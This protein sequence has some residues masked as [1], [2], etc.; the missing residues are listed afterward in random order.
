MGAGSSDKPSVLWK[1]P[2]NLS[3]FPLSSE[4]KARIASSKRLQLTT[5]DQVFSP[6]AGGRKV[7]RFKD[8]DG[9]TFAVEGELTRA[10]LRAKSAESG[11]PARNGEPRDE[12]APLVPVQSLGHE[13]R[14][15]LGVAQEDVASL[16][17]LA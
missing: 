2:A 6:S 9:N 17:V 12:L 3:P 7:A 8:P 14:R 11:R 5:D 1:R 16:P 15:V 10:R 4:R 13:S